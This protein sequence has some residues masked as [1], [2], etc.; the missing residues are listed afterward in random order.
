[1]SAEVQCVR[2][3]QAYPQVGLPYYCPRCGG[4]FDYAGVWNFSPD[5]LHD[6]APGVWPNLHALGWPSDWPVISLGEGNTPLIWADVLGRRVA[7]K[8]EFM[9]PTG[10]FKDR[11]SAAL[12]SLLLS[13]GVTEAVEDSSGNA[14]ASFAAYAARAGIRARVFAP[15]SASGPKRAQIE[16]YGADLV[17]VPGPRSAAAQAALR[18][19]NEGAVYASHAWLPHHL[20]GYATLAVELWRQLGRAPAAVLLPVGQGGLLLGVGRGFQAMRAAGLIENAP[21]MIGVQARA[22]APICSL[23]ETG[24]LARSEHATLAEGVRVNNPLRADAVV[25]AV[26]ASGGKFLAIDEDN[27][28]PGR[29]ELARLGLYVEPTSALVWRAL[30]LTLVDLPDP[31][32]V[33]LTGSG[34]KTSGAL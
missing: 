4:L 27:I 22:C 20:L 8:S 3:G 25:T 19:V 10:S 30:E 9:N 31:V 24:R 15:A 32:V 33:I 6:S 29:D 34:L 13:R 18:A 12:V 21:K 1:M 14:G 17:T 7:F 23:F 26:R 11:G 2:C 5:R 28:L 16:A